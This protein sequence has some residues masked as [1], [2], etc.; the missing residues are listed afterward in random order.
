MTRKFAE[1]NDPNLGEDAYEQSAR[2]DAVDH[3]TNSHL[4]NPS[5]NKYHDVL[6]K[7][8]DNSLAAGLPDISCAPSQAKYLSLQV[9][10]TRAKNVL[11][12]GTLGGYSA[13]WM[14]SAGSHVHVT[15]VEVD[16]HHKK[17][18]EQNIANAGLS[19]QI[20]V[21]LGP[22]VNVLS[23]LREEVASGKRQQFDFV[24]IDADK[25]NNLTY[26]Q[27]GLDMT[28]PGT[29]FFI[30]NVVRRG[31]LANPV[32]A[33]EDSRVKATRELVETVGTDERLE[34]VVVQTVSE[35]NYDGFL[36]AVKV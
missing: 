21:L 5:R 3:Y 7:A 36:M 23:K 24:F 34:A 19:D 20:D 13:I 17:V 27:I 9:R 18:A 2:V 15:T 1:H 32:A 22:G 33:K 12:V 28:T 4:L 10:A 6:E 11:E 31:K 8:Y 25:E 16:P 29:S 26:L 14:A 30:D 35:K